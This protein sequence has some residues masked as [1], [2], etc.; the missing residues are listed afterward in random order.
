MKGLCVRAEQGKSD[1]A[2]FVCMLI[3]GW[4]CSGCSQPSL[5]LAD[6]CII[7]LLSLLLFVPPGSDLNS[8]SMRTSTK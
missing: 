2:Q 8:D 1:R 4:S 3:N 5:G 6:K 7:I